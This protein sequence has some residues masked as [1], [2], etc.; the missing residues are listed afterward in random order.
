MIYMCSVLGKFRGRREH[1]QLRFAIE[2]AE[3]RRLHELQ[4]LGF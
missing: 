3:D 4:A 2:K 1:V